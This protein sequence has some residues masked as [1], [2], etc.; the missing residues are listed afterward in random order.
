MAEFYVAV[1]ER[2][3]DGY[4]AFFPDVPGCTSAGDTVQEAARSAEDALQGH[5]TL[6]LE[7]GEALPAASVLDAIPVDPEVAEVARVLVWGGP[8][9]G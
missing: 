6:A 4:Y 5:L 3:D 7:H 8:S 9:V 1:I 2:G